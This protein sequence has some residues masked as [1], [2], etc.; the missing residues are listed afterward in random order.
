MVV[1]FD[2]TASPPATLRAR[3]SQRLRDVA[4]AK[5]DGLA[6][7]LGALAL[8]SAQWRVAHP[9]NTLASTA[10]AQIH[11]YGALKRALPDLER[12]DVIFVGGTY[13]GRRYIAAAGHYYGTMHGDWLGIPASGKP[14]GLRYGEV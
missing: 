14:V 10:E 3:V 9:I 1:D 4:E 6:A 5:P 11:A 2:P 12:R 7:A 13:Q 8:P